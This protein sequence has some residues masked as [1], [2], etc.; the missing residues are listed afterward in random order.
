MEDNDLDINALIEKYE[1]M[2][3]IGRKI[4]LD[5]DEFA[6]LAEYYNAEGDNAEAEDLIEE[7][8]KMHPGSPE[9]MVMRAKM[10]VY[11]EKFDEALDYMEGISD[12]GS[13]DLAL[14]KA[15][16][17]LHL[18]RQA[19]ADRIINL[20]LKQDL[21]VDDLYF[22]IT[23][24]GYLF[25]D[26][27]IYD[28]AISFLEQSLKINDAN[29]D[30]IVDLAYAYEMKGDLDKAI[31]L[32]NRLLDSDPYSFD[33][34][35][36]LG[37]LYSMNNQ[38]DKAID[39][40]DFALT[41]ND[42]DVSVLKM[43]ALSLYLNDNMEEAAALFEECL[44]KAPDDESVYDSLMEAYAGLEWHDKMMKLLDR[45]EVLLGSE[46]IL[47]KRAFV[48]IHQDDYETAKEIFNQ[49]PETEKDTFD[50]FM[51][52]GELA[53]H[54]EDYAAAEGAYMKAALVS[55]GNEDVLDRLANINVALEKFE[56]AANYLE[57]LLELEPDFP[58]AKSRLAF[59]RFEIGSKEPFDKI[60]EQFS[61]D[62]LRNLLA[63]I[64][65]NET[66]DLPTFNRQQLLTRLNEARENRVL[67]KNMKY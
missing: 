49:I 63:T 7:G 9:L 24:L 64:T 54:D 40:F 14:L 2:R 52:E 25:N 45:R 43:K 50:Y 58:T 28:R 65:G 39:A 16:A 35:V 53:F 20:A 38:H 66:S 10:L 27:D 22:F 31:E 3:A 42:D 47:S 12:D 56:Q 4:Y 46:G 18:D 11:A 1:H 29:N 19:D 36:N 21:P 60:M 23:E 51:L 5:A 13:V 37:K 32:N 67:F 41:I 6:M 17:F 57:E 15:E 33:G 59:I 8:L 34:W 44:M 26:V 55:E 30:A 48:Y 62:E 61:D